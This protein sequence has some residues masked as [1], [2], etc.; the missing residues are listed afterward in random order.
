MGSSHTLSLSDGRKPEGFLAVGVGGGGGAAA[1]DD[2]R[3]GGGVCGR[4]PTP[5]RALAAFL[6]PPAGCP[7][8]AEPLP[9]PAERHAYS[10][11]LTIYTISSPPLFVAGG[12]TLGDLW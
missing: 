11:R 9:R 2:R 6:Q 7:S 5:C 3:G 1:A 8:R 4:R 12:A 10:I